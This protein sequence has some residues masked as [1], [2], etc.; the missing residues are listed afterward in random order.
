MGKW[1]ARE[2]GGNTNSPKAETHVL[3][4]SA[5][6]RPESCSYMSYA[7]GVTPFWR[8]IKQRL[9][10]PSPVDGVDIPLM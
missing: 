8:Q 10:F 1:L 9:S 4:A 7:T 3:E 2:A 6:A 5:Q